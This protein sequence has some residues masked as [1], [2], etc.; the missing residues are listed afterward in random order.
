MAKFLASEP[1]AE[2]LKAF[3]NVAFKEQNFKL[4][5]HMWP[6]CMALADQRIKKLMIIQPPG[7]GKSLL[8]SVIY[9]AWRLGINPAEQILA[10]SAGEKLV[11]G[12]MESAGNII[13]TKEYETIFPKTRPDKADGWSSQKGI[14]VVGRPKGT[15]D[16][17]YFACGIDSSTLTGLHCTQMILDDL[18]NAANSNTADACEKVVARYYNTILGR[19]DPRGCRFIVAGRR[20]HMHDIYGELAKSE[21]YVVMTLPAERP[22]TDKC[23]MD[24]EVPDGLEC[25]FTDGL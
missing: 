16:A 17:S 1:T 25:V 18:H 8:L 9:P 5:P 19:A 24:I 12:F 11:Q 21:E 2:G 10:V 23:W 3:Y 7:L 6:V 14:N 15:P 22:N 20:W 13:E 4:A